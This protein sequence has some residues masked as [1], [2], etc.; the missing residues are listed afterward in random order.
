MSEK[1]RITVELELPATMN[2]RS[3]IS[4]LQTWLSRWGGSVTK[5][6][7]GRGRMHRERQ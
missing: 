3:F 7:Q 6:S 1:V 5:W 2:A 4:G